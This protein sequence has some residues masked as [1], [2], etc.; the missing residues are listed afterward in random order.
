MG[1]L[2]LAMSFWPLPPDNQVWAVSL[3]SFLFILLGISMDTFRERISRREV[4]LYLSL[5][6]F[7]LVVTIFSTRWSG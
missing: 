3:G 1:E 2:A 4:Y 5:G 6:I 7:V